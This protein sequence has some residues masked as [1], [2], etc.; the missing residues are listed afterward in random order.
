MTVIIQVLRK[1]NIF[2]RKPK[3]CAFRETL[4]FQSHSTDGKRSKAK[5]NISVKLDI[6]NWQNVNKKRSVSGLNEGF[7]FHFYM[8]AGKLI[9]ASESGSHD[10]QHLNGNLTM[11]KTKKHPKKPWFSKLTSEEMILGLR[12]RFN[13]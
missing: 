1:K 12:F 13:I 6:L 8:W 3:F 10:G 4:K 7:T 5:P 2:F 11:P 9:K